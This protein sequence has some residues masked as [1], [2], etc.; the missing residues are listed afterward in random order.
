MTAKQIYIDFYKPIWDEVQMHYNEVQHMKD[1]EVITDID[2]DTILESLKK[3][4]GGDGF[5]ITIEEF[6]SICFINVVTYF[7][8]DIKEL[9][10]YV[11]TLSKDTLITKE[12]EIE[13]AIYLSVDSISDQEDIDRLVTLLK[14]EGIEIEFELRRKSAFER[15]AGDFHEDLILS[16]LSA[17]TGKLT[18][19]VFDK[20]QNKFSARR[21]LRLHTIDIERLKEYVTH[22]TSINV[23][24]LKVRSIKTLE[25]GLTEVILTSR[26]K[27]VV[28]TADQSYKHI[29][30][31]VVQK[32]QTLI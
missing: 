9:E 10:E 1:L 28:V 6:D 32:T 12:N 8:Q 23:N 3:Y 7:H 21:N 19:A 27:D 26:Y 2:L 15:G 31:N 22:K 11:T 30:F 17:I 4:L 14:E 16:V 20:V 5:Y 25:A 18:E 29:D 24:D 13:H